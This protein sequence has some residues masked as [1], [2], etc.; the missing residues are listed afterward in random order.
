MAHKVKCLYCGQQFDRDW[1]PFVK[2]TAQRYAHKECAENRGKEIPIP[3]PVPVKQKFSKE[4][5]DS[6]CDKITNNIT[7]DVERIAKDVINKSI[8]ENNEKMILDKVFPSIEKKFTKNLD[9]YLKFI[10]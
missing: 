10:K 3:I 6:L 9:F 4:E 8:G 7:E 1:E 5:I 2:V